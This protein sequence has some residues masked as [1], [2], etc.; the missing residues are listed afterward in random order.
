MQVR[1]KVNLS[2]E[3]AQLQSIHV[4]YPEKNLEFVSYRGAGLSCTAGTF[5]WSSAV[6]GLTTML[7]RAR[8]NLDAPHLSG[9]R[10]SAAAAVE[11]AVTKEPQWLLDMF[12][13][14]GAGHSLIRRFVRR[15]NPNMKR[16]G[17]AELTVFRE[18]SVS[19]FSGSEMLFDDNLVRSALTRLEQ[20]WRPY[21]S[22]QVTASG[23]SPAKIDA[24]PSIRTIYEGEVRRAVQDVDI[25]DQIALN[26]RIKRITSHPILSE[27]MGDRKDSFYALCSALPAGIRLGLS[28]ESF[29]QRELCRDEPVRVAISVVSA[30]VYALFWYLRRVKGYNIEIDNNFAYALEIAN[31]I[32]SGDPTIDHDLCA[33]ADVPSSMMVARSGGHEYRPVMLL[34]SVCQ[35][36]IAPNA[37]NGVE[38]TTG[39][40][41]L[42]CNTPSTADVY[43]RRLITNGSIKKRQI[44][45]SHR[46]PDEAG[47]DLSTGDPDVRAILFFPYFQIN[48]LLNG[49]KALDQPGLPD[50]N[51]DMLLFGHASF[52]SNRSRMLALQI[53]LRD[54]WYELR[55]NPTLSAQ[56][57]ADFTSVPDFRR[58]LE[59]CSGFSLD[60][61]YAA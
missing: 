41:R 43:F 32:L 19:V 20:T 15:F 31:R 55:Q 2:S 39:S 14:D 9:G 8:L 4:S 37:N 35:R 30:G 23:G 3:T 21:G 50:Q 52:I 54:A 59:R 36:V 38:L 27:I 53:A 47:S 40:Y 42:L 22:R 25:F 11:Y 29:L 28:S 60:S 1:I 46:E 5:T 13:T 6:H 51:A 17:P 49:C 7:L 44:E 45:S 58:V 57:A 24:V 33:I 10:G 61:L 34:P 56:A 12:G 26:N 18:A 16:P 48:Q